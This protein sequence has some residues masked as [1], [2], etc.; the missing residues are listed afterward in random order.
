MQLIEEAEERR[1][2]IERFLDRF[3]RYYTPA[4]MLLAVAVIWC[5]RCCSHSRGIPDLSRPDA[6]AD[7]LP[8]RIGDLDPGGITSGLAA[9]TR[10]GALIKGGAA[11]E[12]LGQIK[13][14]PSIKPVP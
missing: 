3:S 14:S 8:M 10:R 4:I 5:R 9:A 1:A 6:A 2:P 11:L 12:Q 7:R 13:L